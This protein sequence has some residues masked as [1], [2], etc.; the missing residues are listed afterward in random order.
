MGRSSCRNTAGNAAKQRRHTLLNGER[1]SESPYIV[2]APLPFEKL[3]RLRLDEVYLLVFTTWLKIPGQFLFVDS[4][5]RIPSVRS[6]SCSMRQCDF[7]TVMTPVRF[8]NVS[9]K[10]T[11]ETSVCLPVSM[12]VVCSAGV[13]C[14]LP[15]QFWRTSSMT[16]FIQ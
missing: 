12:V 3:S 10:V 15:G 2:K 11:M 6:C 16:C 7:H 4:M 5:Q 8:F 1:W 14:R 13:V 9:G